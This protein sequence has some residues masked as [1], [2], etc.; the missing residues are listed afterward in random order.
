MGTVS[1]ALIFT[2]L[3]GGIGHLIFI[4]SRDKDIKK[5]AKD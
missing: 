2:V 1:V 4:K 3:G 5:D